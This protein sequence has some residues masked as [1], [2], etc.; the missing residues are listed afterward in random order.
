MNARS[1]T[2]VVIGAGHNGLAMSRSLTNLSI[3]HVVL[4]RGD[5]A[6]AWRHER[7]DSLRLLTPNWLSRLPGYAY[8]REHGGSDPDG[9]MTMSETIEFITGYAR[10]TAAPVLTQTRVER[11]DPSG[12][13]YRVT[14][15]QGVWHC[16]AV[17]MANGAFG[18]PKVPSASL[19]VPDHIHMITPRSYRRPDQLP[20]GGVLVVGASASGIQ[21]AKEIHESGRP[22]TLATGEHVRMPRTYRGKDILWWMDATGRSNEHIDEVDDPVRVRSVPSPQLI[23]TADRS[24]V[25]MNTLTDIGV[26]IVGRVCSIR[27]GA[28]QTSGD[29]RNLC[30][31]ADLKGGRLLRTVDAWV[32]DNA[33]KR[34]DVA[35]VAAAFP[36]GETLEPT[37]VPDTPRMSLDLNSGEFRT[38]VWATGYSA[39]YRWLNVPV[40]D[41]KGQLRHDGGVVRAPGMYAM[42][43]TFLR[44][45][46]S[47]FIHGAEDDARDLSVHLAG[48]LANEHQ[49]AEGWR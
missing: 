45:R 18:I 28:C 1:I 41:H 44:R 26:E 27:N 12:G 42:G 11:V 8:G 3:D 31:M 2:T 34:E 35:Q 17:V 16:R 24:T 38:I 36:D 32:I 5:V 20:D 33:D 22:V 14:T 47:S 9:F 21:L 48:Y 13:G 46:K 10:Y 25:D 29:L 4:E 39:D 7:W 23:G 49:R 6:N 15:N 43:H 37:R 19:A 30:T 40:L